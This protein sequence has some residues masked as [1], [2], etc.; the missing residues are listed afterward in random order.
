MLPSITLMSGATAIAE[1]TCPITTSHAGTPLPAGT[2]AIDEEK[3]GSNRPTPRIS[4]NAKCDQRQH[5]RGEPG[6]E[7]EPLG[8]E[9]LGS[10]YSEIHGRMKR[11]TMMALLPAQKWPD[12]RNNGGTGNPESA[13]NSGRT[14]HRL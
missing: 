14:A 13:R 8:A 6:P 5:W 11:V 3:V 1:T 9:P 10:A 2:A 12:P 7:I 4:V